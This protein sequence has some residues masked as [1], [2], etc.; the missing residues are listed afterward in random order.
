METQAP[1]PQATEA[2]PALPT[3]T[4]PG[5]SLCVD[6]PISKLAFF[7]P[8]ILASSALILS[9]K[10][11]LMTIKAP[12]LPYQCPVMEAHD[13]LPLE[14]H[15]WVLLPS[16]QSPLLQISLLMMFQNTE[17]LTLGPTLHT[18]YASDFNQL[19]L[20]V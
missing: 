17:M 3:A 10:G 12:Q 16:I 1:G 18:L 19:L 14:L 6:S 2:R 4:S 5:S 11:A 9:T 15:F 7:E 20:P 8:D 13:H